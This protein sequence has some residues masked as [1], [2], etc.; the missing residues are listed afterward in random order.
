MNRSKTALSSFL[1]ATCFWMVFSSAVIASKEAGT[2]Q[3]LLQDVL[4][5]VC[6]FTGQFKQTKNMQGVPVSLKSDGDFLYSC[7]LGLIWNTTVPFNETLLVSHR[8]SSFRI[9]ENGR[10]SSLQGALRY[11]MSK[12]FMRL[13]KGDEDFF[14]REFAIQKTADNGITELRPESDFM[15]KGIEVIRIS[16]IEDEET[17]IT[18]N[19]EILRADEQSSTIDIFNLTE[20]THVESRAQA[21][22]YCETV[23][24]STTK[25]CKI[26][27]QPAQFGR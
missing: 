25:W 17:G 7:R 14:A 12:I 6:S 8:R 24:Q 1:I 20:A 10:V 27:R 22:K 13:L 4:P 23:Y 2:E 5:N 21:F 16:K 15:K 3:T 18:L 19:I 26:L 11:S 9:D